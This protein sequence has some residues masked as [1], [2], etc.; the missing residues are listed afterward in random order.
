[1][2]IQ[3]ILVEL[4]V[5]THVNSSFSGFFFRDLSMNVVSDF[6]TRNPY[7]AFYVLLLQQ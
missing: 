4:F 6:C 1:M 2:C 7:V 5:E 3:W